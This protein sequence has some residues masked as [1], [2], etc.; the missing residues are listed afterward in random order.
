MLELH[1]VIFLWLIPT[2]KSSCWFILIKDSVESHGKGKPKYYSLAERRDLEPNFISHCL[3]RGDKGCNY[4]P[5]SCLLNVIMVFSQNWTE[6]KVAW[7][8]LRKQW[9]TFCGCP[10]VLF[11][12]LVCVYISTP[13]CLYSD[14]KMCFYSNIINVLRPG[15]QWSGLTRKYLSKI[16]RTKFF[17]KV[18]LLSG[19]LLDSLNLPLSPHC[20]F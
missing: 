2:A 6:L 20:D 11:L 5:K 8:E 16:Q 7:L 10:K 14:I 9:E 13:V 19:S 4:F 18:L 15:S 3:D 12:K 1:P 17:S